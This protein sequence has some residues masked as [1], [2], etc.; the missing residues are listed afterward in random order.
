MAIASDRLRRAKPLLGTFVE[1][2]AAGAAPSQMAAAID[3]AFEVVGRVHALMSFH[4]HDSDVSRLNRE[5]YLRPTEVHAWTFAVLHAAVEMNR[6]SN[7]IFDIAVAPALQII[8]LLPRPDDHP[9][10]A[11]QAR[12]IDAIE[13]GEGQAVRFRDRDVMI[14]LGGIAKGF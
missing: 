14:D 5:A 12:S 1:I 6:R 11:M 3:A 7:G 9:A 2:E 4:A 8:G 10:I 13:L